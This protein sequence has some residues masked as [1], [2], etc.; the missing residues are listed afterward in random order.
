MGTS[1][2]PLSLLN[3]IRSRWSYFSQILL[4]IPLSLSLILLNGV[5]K[6]R[7]I[8]G[9]LMSLSVFTLSFLFIVSPISNI[10]NS[11]FSPN[12]GVRFAYTKSE[13]IA[14][15]FF[16][17]NSIGKISSDFDYSTNPS[18]SIFANYYNVSYDRLLSL[19][20]SLYNGSFE[21]DGSIK[22]IRREIVNSPFRL[23]KGLYRLH[24]DPNIVL[25]NSGFN[26]IYDSS[27]ITAYL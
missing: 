13:M 9:F 12:T 16:A 19:D 3:I 5:F 22:I 1:W 6:H 8:K 23:A 14:A 27:T 11:F 21:H 7:F 26:R 10:D 2:T 24:Y 25:L 18:S 17:Q 20:D 15:S 4:A